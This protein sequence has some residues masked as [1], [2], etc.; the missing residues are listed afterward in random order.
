MGVFFCSLGMK[1]QKKTSKRQP[2]RKKYKVE[3]K[4]REHNRKA[5][6]DSRL[7]PKSG[8]KK[9]PGIPNLWPFKEQMLNRIQAQQ[10]REEENKQQKREERKQQRKV[11][12][13]N[14][15]VHDAHRRQKE[16]EHK[17]QTISNSKDI[18]FQQLPEQSKR[19]YY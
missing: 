9:D 5:R 11:A 2:L 6:K 18:D 12:S 13:I 14:D 16:F 3:R 17:E 15:L 10:E 19:A 8:K 7:N 4:V 1:V